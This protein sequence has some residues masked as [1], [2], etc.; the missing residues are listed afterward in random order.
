MGLDT[1]LRAIICERYTAQW[2][3]N[4]LGDNGSAGAALADG[5]ADST[6][7]AADAADCRVRDAFGLHV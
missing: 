5:I 1:L 2:A 7:A 4:E 6:D 3:Q